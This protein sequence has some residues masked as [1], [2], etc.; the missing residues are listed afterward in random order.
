MSIEDEF[1]DAC[2]DAIDECRRMTPRYIPSAW[3]QMIERYGAVE[4]ARRVVV[5]GDIQSGF[6]ELVGRGRSNLTIEAAVLNPRWESLFDTQIQQAARWR[7]SQAGID[8]EP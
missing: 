5:S 3:I 6:K 4:A 7:L 1:E 8:N 2:R